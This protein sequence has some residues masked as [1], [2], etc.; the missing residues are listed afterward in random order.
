[1]TLTVISENSTSL[2]LIT[3]AICV[4]ASVAIQEGTLLA[5]D[6]IYSRVD[7]HLV[8][9]QESA[10]GGQFYLDLGPVPVYGLARGRRSAKKGA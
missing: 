1:M 4:S 10:S 3:Q 5:L 8:G 7:R 9:G 6:E 2:R